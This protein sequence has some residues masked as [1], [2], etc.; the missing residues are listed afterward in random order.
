MYR[1]GFSRMFLLRLFC[2]AL[3]GLGLA[4]PR[5][6]PQ[7]PAASTP[8]PAVVQKA[9][10]PTTAYTLPPDKLQ[11]A[12]ALYI[13]EGNLIVISSVYSFVVLLALLSLG[14]VARYRDWAEMASSKRF[15]QALI[16]VP[17]VLLTLD[18]LHLPFRI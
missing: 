1:L 13:L 4:A 5:A 10:A 17:L 2:L 18:V 8:A 12:Q 7:I 11:K 14:I 15:V 6:L 3:V 9:P 16:V